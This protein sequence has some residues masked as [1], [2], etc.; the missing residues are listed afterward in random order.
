VDYIL[1][2]GDNMYKSVPHK[3]DYFDYTEL[4]L[5]VRVDNWSANN[6]F[7]D[8]VSGFIHTEHSTESAISFPNALTQLASVYSGCLLT[9]SSTTVAV[10]SHGSSFL[11]F[12]SHSRDSR[13]FLMSNGTAVLLEFTSAEHLHQHLKHMYSIPETA[14]SC[15]MR[16]GANHDSRCQFDI[17][18]LLTVV[19]MCPTVS[20]QQPADQHRGQCTLNQQGPGNS[21]DTSRNGERSSAKC[22]QVRDAHSDIAKETNSYYSRSGSPDYL[23]WSYMVEVP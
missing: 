15:L 17:V 5:Y 20:S 10:I 4:P 6:A 13:G 16:F 14:A 11:L 22:A 3:N 21:T 23:K 2:Q 8:H 12:D 7:G 9:I 18:P 1:R 19:Q